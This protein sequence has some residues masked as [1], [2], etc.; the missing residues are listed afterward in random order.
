MC[1][2]DRDYDA[3]IITGSKHMADIFEETTAICKKPKKVSNWL[4]GETLRLLKEHEKE[5]EDIAF[6]AEN[7]A[8][9]IELV[10]GGVIN[11]NVAKEVFEQIFDRN[12]DPVS[13]T[14]L[15]VYKR[16]RID[17][18]RFFMSFFNHRF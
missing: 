7:L 5:P 3:Q 9:L 18:D 1:I 11:G 16:Q 14:H 6:S 4:M 15:D 8:K 17:F 2:R 12:I 13:Y 10:D